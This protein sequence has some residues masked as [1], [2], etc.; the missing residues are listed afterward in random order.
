MKF[1]V[2]IPAYN[3]ESLIGGC[4]RNIKPYINDVLVLVSEKPYYREFDAPDKTRDISEKL[5]C[6]VVCGQWKEEH[7]QR[8]LGNIL[9]KDYDWIVWMDAD[10]RWTKNN[11]FRLLSYLK[12]SDCDAVM[13]NHR[14]YWK[15]IGN[16]IVDDFKP[17][18]AVRPNVR[19]Y[20]ICSVDPATYNVTFFDGATVHHLAWCSPKDIRKKVMTYGHSNEFDGESWFYKY[21]QSWVDGK[22]IMPDGRSYNIEKDVFPEELLNYI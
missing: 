20:K 12:V 4:I 22:V 16:Y 21:Y 8:N 5:G 19:F 6:D 2:A 1:A 14:S 9:L 17:I 18:V 7:E 3:E 15:E 13:A 11:I 10:M